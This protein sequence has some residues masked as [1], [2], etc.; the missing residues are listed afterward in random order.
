VNNVSKVS[1]VS[2]VSPLCPVTNN[3]PPPS[4][5]AESSVLSQSR[6]MPQGNVLAL[7]G[8]TESNVLD[9]SRVRQLKRASPAAQGSLRCV[10]ET[11]PLGG[12]TAPRP[13][14]SS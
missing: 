3:L 13:Q 2:N 6:G 8:V 10:L 12:R 7:S 9:Q 14:I 11:A 1:K 4:G 5:V